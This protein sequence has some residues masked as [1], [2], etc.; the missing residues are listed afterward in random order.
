MTPLARAARLGAALA[1][2][3]AGGAGGA[4]ACAICLSAIS[5]TT[6]ERLD[7]SDRAV[8]AVADGDGLRV[9]AVLKGEAAIGEII[10]GPAPEVPPAGAALLMARNALGQDWRSLGATDPANA[11]WLRQIAET[12]RLGTVPAPASGRRSAGSRPELSE[13]AMQARLALALPRLEDPDPLVAEIAHDEVA[14]APYGMLATLADRL[15][16]EKLRAWIADPGDATRRGTYI[17]LLGVAG[18]PD[19]AA[20]LELR[21][22]A[23]RQAHDATDVAALL[24]A[25]LELNGPGRVDFIERAYISDRER[26]LPEIEAALLALG[27]HGGA[28]GTVPRARVVEAYRLLIRERPPMAGFVALE[29]ADWGAWEATGDYVR[30]IETN[31]VTD[32][33]EEF[34][35]LSYLQRS[36]DPAARAALADD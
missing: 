15:D 5:V 25:D 10:P 31:R 14:R 11:A 12:A 8:L 1:I 29:L 28:E 13:P 22:D 18:A 2:L 32:P 16:P 26:T 20:A 24:A 17:V 6:G 9:V 19:D 7:A 4:A 27:V 36:P 23:A 33:A 21:L 3:I 34:A 30:L 35:I